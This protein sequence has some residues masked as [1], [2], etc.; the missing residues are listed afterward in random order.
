MVNIS[1]HRSRL[2]PQ[3]QLE[4]GLDPAQLGCIFSASSGLWLSER[5][6]SGWLD[7]CGWGHADPRPYRRS[8]VVG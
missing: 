7:H 2:P 8:T 5:F 6:R 3:L 4:F 1:T